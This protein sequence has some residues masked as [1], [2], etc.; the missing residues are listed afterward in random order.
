MAEHE[1]M[2][3]AEGLV[4]RLIARSVFVIQVAVGGGTGC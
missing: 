3:N 1:V 2:L 4:Q